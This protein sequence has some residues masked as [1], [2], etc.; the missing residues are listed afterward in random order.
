MT[1]ADEGA[2]TLRAWRA[3][4]RALLRLLPVPLHEKQG[5]AM[6][7]RHLRELRRRGGEGMLAVCSAGVAGMLDLVRRGCY[8]RV[9]EERR[10]LTSG[11]LAQIGRMAFAFFVTC[12][13]LTLLMVAKVVLTGAAARANGRTFDVVLLSIPFTA[14]LT[15]PMAVFIAVLWTMSVGRSSTAPIVRDGGPTRDAGLLRLA[16]VIG[17]ASIVAVFCLVLNTEV[18]PRA[19]LR[20]QA[21]ASGRAVVSPTDRS[22]TL[23][24]LRRAEAQ[25]V[26][27]ADGATTAG[28]AVTTAATYGVEIHKKFALAAACVVLALCA[29]AI[30]RR[31]PHA[32]VLAQASISVGV[33]AGYYVCLIAGEQLADGA[34]VSPAVAMWSANGI[35]LGLAMLAFRGVRGGRASRRQPR[36]AGHGDAAAR[37]RRVPVMLD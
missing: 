4:Y 22:M 6:L 23:Q 19:N 7:D 32:G 34:V 17:V 33:F 28:S 27:R 11:G 5:E 9:M 20:L 29:A 16:P 36:C 12:S 21:L 24:Q 13:A 30:A 37:L 31:V 15:V 3:A 26:S 1:P 35:V 8:E 25:P 18:V 10:A 2:H 14:A